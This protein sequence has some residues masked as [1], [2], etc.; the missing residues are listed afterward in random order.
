MTKAFPFESSRSRAS[1]LTAFLFA[2]ACACTGAEAQNPIASVRDLIG[3]WVEVRETI[4]REKKEWRD[5]RGM[6]ESRIALLDQE[7]EQLGKKIQEDIRKVGEVDAKRA[8]VDGQ[9]GALRE[10]AD[11]LLRE[12]QGVEADLGRRLLKALPDPLKEKLAPLAQRI[13]ADPAGSGLTLAERYQN[14]IGILNEINKFNGQVSVVSEIRAAQG[15]AVKQ[16]KTLYLGVGQG[17][18][19]SPEGDFAGAGSPREDGWAWEDARSSADSIKRAIA[20][21]DSKHGAADFVP[22]PI[23]VEDR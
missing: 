20:M 21:L 9:M 23:R 4:A 15:G 17:Y 2:A 3:K 6:L 8:E 13:P 19:V 14:V 12:I 7:I 5:G 11:V 1:A 10:G 18:F 22:L 16:V